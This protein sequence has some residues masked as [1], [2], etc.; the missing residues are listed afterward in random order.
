MGG[1]LVG[2]GLKERKNE[3]MEAVI[4]INS[5]KLLEEKKTDSH[6]MRGGEGKWVKRATGIKNTNFQL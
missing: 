1:M 3:D 2:I 6:Q 4:R 5:F